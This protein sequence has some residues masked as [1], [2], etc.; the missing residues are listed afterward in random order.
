[1]PHDRTHTELSGSRRLARRP[2][3]LSLLAF[4][5]LLIVWIAIAL[6]GSDGIGEHTRQTLVSVSL[7]RHR[8][9]RARSRPAQA[10]GVLGIA[11][12]CAEMYYEGARGLA[13]QAS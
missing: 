13:P 5:G 10:A 6:A 8:V 4:V 3:R 9:A 1:L 7:G 11:T 2:P 12:A